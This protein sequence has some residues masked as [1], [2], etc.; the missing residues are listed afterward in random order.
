MAL[1][2]RS[3]AAMTAEEWE[4]A[5]VCSAH[6]CALA[7]AQSWVGA[8]AQLVQA[9]YWILIDPPKSDRFFERFFEIETST[10]RSPQPLAYTLLYL[11]RLLRAHGRDEA[12]ALLNDWLADLGESTDPG[13]AMAGLFALYG[14]TRTAL[15][16]RSRTAPR[17]VPFAQLTAELFQSTLASALG[18]FDEAEQHVATA[19]SVVRDF[20]VPRMEGACLI[21]FAKVALDR[22]DYARA[23]RL[24]ATAE[25]SVRPEHKPFQ[26]LAEILVYDY[27]TDVLRDVLDPDSLRTTQAEGAAVSLNEALDAEL[28]RSA[29][30]AMADPAE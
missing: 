8:E 18:D 27:C 17:D 26:E 11:S 9:R 22:G 2:L 7:D 30:T 1:Y 12:L 4:E 14:D 19:V 21:A 24:L 28:L 13:P 20:A 3:V 6:A 15:E 16:L 10:G 23:S 29:T 5:N 25:S